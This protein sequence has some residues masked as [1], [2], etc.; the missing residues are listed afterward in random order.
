MTDVGKV[1]EVSRAPLLSHSLVLVYRFESVLGNYEEVKS[2]T[3][4]KRKRRIYELFVLS[5]YVCLFI[6]RW[7]LINLM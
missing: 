1:W 2:R 6:G 7:I 4:S 3:K 5:R